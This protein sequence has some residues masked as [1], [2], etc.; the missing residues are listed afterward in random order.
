MLLCKKHI[1][2]N[3][4][5]AALFQELAHFFE[6]FPSKRREISIAVLFM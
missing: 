3:I 2:K 5:K 4:S 6:V 1:R